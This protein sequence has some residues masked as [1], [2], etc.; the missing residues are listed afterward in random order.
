MQCA[1]DR[2]AGQCGNEAR[3]F[4]KMHSIRSSLDRMAMREAQIDALATHLVN[5]LIDRGLIKPKA[6]AKEL[7]AC[8][9]ELMS[10]NFETEA[11][12]DEEADKMAE[13]EARRD[14]RLDV[15]RLRSLIRQRLAEKKNFTL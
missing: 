4:D 6:D 13:A 8:V 1:D 11:Q 12:I 3:G 7:V 2:G 14:T 9:V 15:T 10:A 5:G